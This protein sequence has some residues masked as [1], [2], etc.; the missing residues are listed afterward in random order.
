MKGRED[1]DHA[2]P[3]AGRTPIEF[4]GAGTPSPIYI[5]TGLTGTGSGVK[6]A[7]EV[8]KTLPPGI[9]VNHISAK[10]DPGSVKTGCETNGFFDNYVK[11]IEFE[12]FN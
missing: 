6:N 5:R 12:R 1:R 10:S 8:N 4:E 11:S 7:E 9:T 3:P 2:K